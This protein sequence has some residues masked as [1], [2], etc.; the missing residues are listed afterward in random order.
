MPGSGCAPTGFQWWKERIR[1]QLTQ[2]DLLRIDHF[3]GLEAY[4]EIPASAETAV[5]GRWRQAPG[6]ELFR[7]LRAEFGGLP[8]VAEDLGVITPG[9]SR[10]CAI[11][12]VCRE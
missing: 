2:F 11:R 6:G 7:A 9:R 10:R 5:A 8:L 1:T 12:T 3:R 4:W